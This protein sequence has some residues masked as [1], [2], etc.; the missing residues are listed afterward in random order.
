[1]S[2][3]AQ[4]YTHYSDNKWALRQAT[5]CATVWLSQHHRKQQKLHIIG[6]CS[7]TDTCQ[8]WPVMRKTF[9][10]HDHTMCKRFAVTY[11]ISIWGTL[12]HLQ[13]HWPDKWNQIHNRQ[14]ASPTTNETC[15]IWAWFLSD[16]PCLEHV[17]VSGR[18]TFIRRLRWILKLIYE[19]TNVRKDVHYIH[20]IYSYYIS[21]LYIH[22]IILDW[23]L[24]QIEKNVIQGVRDIALHITLVRNIT[25]MWNYFWCHRRKW[26]LF[27]GW[28]GK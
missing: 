3:I 15:Q 17:L 27:S 9:P 23:R 4:S 22:I 6:L 10:C 18:G 20:T 13:C 5:V 21:I 25:V 19:D 24:H 12:L 1:M 26:K 11:L 2:C 8:K 14:G 7:P 28:F 16:K